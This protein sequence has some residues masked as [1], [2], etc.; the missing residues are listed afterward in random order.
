MWSSPRPWG[1]FSVDI[2]FSGEAAV[3]PTP[4]G[5]FPYILGMISRRGCLPHARGG[6]S[7][8]KM[9]KLRTGLVFPT[10]VGVFLRAGQKIRPVNRSSPRPWGCFPLFVDALIPNAVFPTPVGVFPPGSLSS[11]QCASLPHARGGVS[12]DLCWSAIV[13][14]SSPRPWG[15]FSCFSFCSCCRGV[16]P[17]PVGVFPTCGSILKTACRLPHARGGV[18]GSRSQPGP[19]MPSSPRPWGC[20]QA[21]AAAPQLTP[22]FPTPVGVF[23]RDVMRVFKVSCLPHARGGVSSTIMSATSLSWSSPRPWGCFR[24]QM[25][26]HMR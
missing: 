2:N 19:D 4:V 7:I 18:S 22:V 21:Q 8:R 6:V 20:F 12:Q 17:T 26:R 11:W 1:C 14:E 15:C 23:L 25:R 16:F 13:A 24:I 3:F 9:K 5:V 10:P